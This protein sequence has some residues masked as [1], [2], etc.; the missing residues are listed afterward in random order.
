MLP[1]PT[2]ALWGKRVTFST[3]VLISKKNIKRRDICRN[4]M[5]QVAPG[6]Y[7]S[8]KFSCK[9][10]QSCVHLNSGICCFLCLLGMDSI[11]W[12]IATLPVAI[13]SQDRESTA[14]FLASRPRRRVIRRKRVVKAVSSVQLHFFSCG[15]KWSTLYAKVLMFY[16]GIGDRLH[17]CFLLLLAWVV[18]Q[19]MKAQVTC[20]LSHKY[21][22]VRDVSL[23]FS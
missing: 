19:A 9:S 10:R 23:S 20:I 21:S 13:L 1:A 11:N 6:K 17:A 16:P 7:L 15:K 4:I 5:L 8:G 12:S 22:N 18:T 14:C 2:S 3:Y